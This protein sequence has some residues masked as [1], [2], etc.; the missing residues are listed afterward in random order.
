MGTDEKLALW[1]D[2]VVSIAA[3]ALG[4]WAISSTWLDWKNYND[5]EQAQALST[6][7]YTLPNRIDSSIQ[8]SELYSNAQDNIYLVNVSLTNLSDIPLTA[9]YGKT[10]LQVSQVV[11]SKLNP[12]FSDT[13][14]IGDGRYGAAQ[15]I[16]SP[17]YIAP[18]DARVLHFIVR[19]EKD[20]IYHMQFNARVSA[21]ENPTAQPI[22]PDTQAEQYF[23]VERA[24]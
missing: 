20:G 13:R 15:G 23:R 6:D 14:S 4:Y 3:V 18:G 12:A 24:L 17:L 21:E 22:T 7:R 19:F 2:G 9:T 5:A 16:G 10:S 11:F 8:V 1:R